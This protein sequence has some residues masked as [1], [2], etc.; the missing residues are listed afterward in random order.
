V[1]NFMASHPAQVKLWGGLVGGPGACLVVC[2]LAL[3]AHAHAAVLQADS[4]RTRLNCL[5]D[6]SD[7]Y[8]DVRNDYKQSEVA[9][10]YNAGLTGGA[11]G[12]AFFLARGDLAACGAG[13]GLPPAPTP[14]TPGT[15]PPPPPPPVQPPPPVPAP[16]PPSG[17]CSLTVQPWAKCGGACVRVCVRQLAGCNPPATLGMP[18]SHSAR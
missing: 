1:T 13:P 9:L 5:A 15:P 18:D 2:A 16:P 14:P 6:Q 7:N 8:P 10:D 3:Q 17:P 11:A 4:A 12:L